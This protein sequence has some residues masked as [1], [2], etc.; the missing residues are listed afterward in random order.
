MK[1]KFEKLKS[2]KANVLIFDY[3]W[4]DVIIVYNGHCWESRRN[5]MGQ[6]TGKKNILS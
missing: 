1:H 5:V 3:N 6:N 2:Q 4:S